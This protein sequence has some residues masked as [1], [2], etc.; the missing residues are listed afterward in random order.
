MTVS[1][2]LNVTIGGKGY[3]IEVTAGDYEGADPSVGIMTGGF[4]NYSV[5]S[6]EDD[7]GEELNAEALKELQAAI[8]ADAFANDK[9]LAELDEAGQAEA[10]DEPD[11]YRDID[12][13]DWRYR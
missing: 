2:S 6:A 13:A 5:D 10:D 8:E 4:V 7:D 11:D 12:P 9:V 1:T 3:H